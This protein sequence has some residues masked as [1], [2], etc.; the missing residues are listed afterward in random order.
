MLWSGSW[1]RSCWRDG[2]GLHDDSL[3]SL[4]DLVGSAVR[5]QLTRGSLDDVEAE[6]G[7]GQQPN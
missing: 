1:Y 6:V 3:G 2:G 4:K 5:E 7:T